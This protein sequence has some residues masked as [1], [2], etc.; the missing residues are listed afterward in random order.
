MKVKRYS[1]NSEDK[2]D[3]NSLSREKYFTDHIL[4]HSRSMISIINKDYVYEKVNSAFTNAHHGGIGSI[5]GKSLEDVWGHDIFVNNIKENIDL[6][7]SGSTVRYE[8]SFSTP[9]SGKRHFEVIF[10]PFPSES[11]EITHLF[12]ETFDITDLEL[13]KKAVSEKEEEFRRFETTLPI[14]IL[15]CTPDGRIMHV[16]NSLMLI[17]ECDNEALLCG[18]YLRNNYAEPGLFDEHL[19]QLNDHKPKSFGRIS[20]KTCKGN[21]IVCRISGFLTINESGNPS[22]IDFAF[23][24]SSHELMLEN[25]LMQAQKL[26]A[27]GVLAGGIAHDFNN[28]LATISGYSELLLDDLP[29]SSPSSEKVGKILTAVSKGRSLINQ[30]LVFSRLDKHEKISVSVYEVLKETIGFIKSAVPP[31][32][33]VKGNI[34]KINAYVMADPTQ[35]F[36]MFLNLMTNA[37]QSMEEKGGVLNVDLALAEGKTLHN[38]LNKTEIADEYAL[39]TF[40]DT[41]MGMD[42]SMLTRIFEPFFTTRAVGKGSGLGLSVVYGIVSEMGGEILVS[43][44]KHKGSVF[45]VYLPVAGKKY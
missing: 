7:F 41:G 9:V 42:S 22:Y 18:N 20:L 11:G 26:E 6:C 13:S 27:I 15:R 25:R 45:S 24:D 32:I 31:D 38:E 39:V 36:R 16:N 19:L 29:P 35:L 14:G 37:V 4:D 5:V 44:S 21:E 8:A 40:S 17:M 34:R 28:M 12:A 1:G 33:K 2:N 3:L 23:E 30:I 43:S 10:R